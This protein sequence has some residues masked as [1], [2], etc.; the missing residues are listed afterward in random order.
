M[1]AEVFAEWLR[2]QG[3]HVARTASSYWVAVGPRLYQAF[4]YHWVV[5]PRDAEVLQ[6][7]HEHRAIGLRYSTPVDSG[8]GVLSYHVIREG[9]EYSL[10]DL[11]KK[12]RYD[13]RKGLSRSTIEPIQFSRLATEGW[14]LRL[15]TLERQRRR[16]AESRTWWYKL[17]TSAEDLPGFEAWG[18]LVDGKLAASLLAFTCDGCC[19]ILYHQSK[20]EYLSEGVNNALAFV[21]TSEALKRSGR[22]CV[23][24]GLHS[25][26]APAS[27]DAFKFRMGYTARPVRQRVMF[28]PRLRP[29]FNRPSHAVLRQLLRWQP[30][31]PTLTKAEGMVRF[32]LDGK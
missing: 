16:G 30:D 10:T 5:R 23:F 7:L 29:L 20:S 32:Y 31:R 1:T 12:A 11:P 24:Y 6:F 19:S 26:D 9:S 4:P 14:E 17:C 22:D 28:H 21:F 15:E 25:L 8:Q 13:V 18:V 3:R 27:V 2:R